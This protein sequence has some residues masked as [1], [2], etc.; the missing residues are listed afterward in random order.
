MGE[1]TNMLLILDMFLRFSAF[2]PMAASCST[3]AICGSGLGQL[4]MV[5][6][7]RVE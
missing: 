7:H 5:P 3:G 6:V 4:W 2:V 1:K